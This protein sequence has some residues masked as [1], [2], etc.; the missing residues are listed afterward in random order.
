[1]VDALIKNA[2]LLALEGEALRRVMP[3]RHETDAC[4]NNIAWRAY[5]EVLRGV[6]MP[7]AESDLS[8]CEFKSRIQGRTE[9]ITTYLN[10]K[11]AL[12]DLTFG[13][14]LI[15]DTLIDEV[16]A[17]VYN[18][19]IKKRIHQGHPADRQVLVDIA[20]TAVADEWRGVEGSNRHLKPRRLSPSEG[21]PCNNAFGDRCDGQSNQDNQGRE[22]LPMSQGWPYCNQLLRKTVSRWQGQHAAPGGPTRAT[23]TTRTISSRRS[24][25]TGRTSSY[26]KTVTR[27]DTSRRTASL[28]ELST[29]KKLPRMKEQICLF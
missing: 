15:F 19:V 4:N 27:L 12:A 24:E 17:G 26:V 18:P 28:L 6:F 20:V 13:Q 3:Y 1:M 25:G 23:A 10:S 11:I 8:K 16:I 9:P 7:P 29:F 22:M 2:L 5:L 14:Q 21:P